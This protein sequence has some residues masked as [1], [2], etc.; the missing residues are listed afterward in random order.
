MRVNVV[1]VLLVTAACLVGLAGCVTAPDLGLTQ[2]SQTE[3]A[4]GTD[5]MAADLPVSAETTVETTTA[6]TEVTTTTKVASLGTS[7][8][9]VLGTDPY[10][11]LS[12]GK[13]QYRAAN[14]GLAEEHYRKAVETHPNDAEAWVGLA[15]SYDRLRRFDL[16]DRAYKEAIRIV[17]PTAEVLNNQGFSY[18]LRGEYAKSRTTLRKA[19]TLDPQNV[20][21]LNNINLLEQVARKGKGVG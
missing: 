11:E 5:A 3:T 8:A 9:G 20:Y 6:P 16:A 18:M 10:D 4:P 2:V 17:G 13:K 12:I 1:R 15:A 19:Q 14:Y 7:T 21:I